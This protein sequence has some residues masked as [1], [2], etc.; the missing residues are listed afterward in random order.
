M[1]TD[2][3]PRGMRVKRT[4]LVALA[5]AAGAA[6]GMLV[7][8]VCVVALFPFVWSAGIVYGLWIAF[9]INVILAIVAA[10]R[11]LSRRDK[12]CYWHAVLLGMFALTLFMVLSSIFEYGFHTAPR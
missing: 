8:F 7:W 4:I 2:T 10:A 5:I 11:L 3:Y 6:L 1:T 9:G 12:L